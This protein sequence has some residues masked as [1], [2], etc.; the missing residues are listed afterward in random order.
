MVRKVTGAPEAVRKRVEAALK[1][2]GFGILT[3]IDVQ[4]V[5]R[6]K[7]GAEIEAYTILGACN[8]TLAQAALAVDRSIG[9]LLPCNVTLR[10][11]GGKTEVAMADPQA[12]F[13][14]VDSAVRAKL[15]PLASQA[16]DRL[17]A[18]LSGLE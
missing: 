4:A 10:Q 18:A 8:P 15:A 5:L 2:Q 12:M 1:E 7:L 17:L 14:V 13:Q 3:E 6:E 9:L 16:R 11:M